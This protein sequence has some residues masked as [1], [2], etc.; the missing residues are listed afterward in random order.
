MA[1]IRET[2][3]LAGLTPQKE[4][5]SGVEHEIENVLSY[6]AL[7][8]TYFHT[9][10]DNSLRN[11]GVEF[12]SNPL[13]FVSQVCAF[14]NL[15]GSIKY[16]PKGGVDDAF[17]DRTSIHVHVNCMD[18]S[19]EATK[20]FILW[21]ALFEPV[22]FSFV[23]K[24]RPNSIYCV[25]LDQTVLPNHYSKSVN[26]LTQMWSKYTAFN[27]LPLRS[28]GTIEF[29]HMHGTN[30]KVLFVEWLT[31][32]KQLWEYSQKNFP[33][34]LTLKKDSFVR[35]AFDEIFRS[36]RGATIGSSVTG[37]VENTLIDLKLS[38]L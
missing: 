32:I 10:S 16:R 33:S 17:T 30:D 1:S 12:I 8:H 28:Q 31:A 25:P 37:L 36:T 2:F 26:H 5:I 6:D 18:L 34:K 4:F 21:Y 23:D 27:I 38:F 20:A 19:L 15:H 29:R 3:A 24:K 7:N 35:D 11:N 14:D 9:E 13:N 22:F